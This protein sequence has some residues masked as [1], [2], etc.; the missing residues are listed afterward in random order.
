V[1]KITTCAPQPCFSLSLGS[2][3]CSKDTA[4]DIP[5]G[6]ILGERVQYARLVC[7]CPRS[8]PALLPRYHFLHTIY[9]FHLYVKMKDLVSILLLCVATV[10][11]GDVV[12]VKRQSAS[13]SSAVTDSSSSAVAA[14]SSTS[15]VFSIPTP[16]TLPTVNSSEYDLS[17][18]FCR[19]WRHQSELAEVNCESC[20]ANDLLQACMPMVRSTLTVVIR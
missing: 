10:V 1:Q 16:T 11:V 3:K 2:E 5:L 7:I 6:P 20:C 4:A 19:I 14:S 8:V 12:K 13:S 17:K 9:V 18:H 15:S